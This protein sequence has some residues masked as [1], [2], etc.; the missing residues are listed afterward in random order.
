MLE[1]IAKRKFSLNDQ[2]DFS[3]F[4]GDKNPIHVDKIVARRTL[5]GQCIVHGVHALLR[6]LDC[7]A[8]AKDITATKLKTKFI[9]PG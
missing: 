7:L 3:I 6:A 2:L 4:C 9:K 1:I 8:K 5:N